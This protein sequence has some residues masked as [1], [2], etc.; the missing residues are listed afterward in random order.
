MA[1]AKSVLKRQRQTVRRSARNKS[2]RTRV[3]T[4]ERRVR[5]APSPEEAQ[6]RFRQFQRGID[7][8]AAKGAIHPNK[9][10]RRKAR[11]AKALE[12][13]AAEASGSS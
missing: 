2:V 11:M 7:K 1:R 12:K 13:G 4:L 6:E 3:K 5:E 9:A 8:A 10:A